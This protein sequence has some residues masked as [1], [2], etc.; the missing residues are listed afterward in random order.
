[1]QHARTTLLI[2]ALLGGTAVVLGA[3]GAHALKQV[4]AAPQ[5]ASFETAVRFQ[6]YHAFFLMGVGLLQ[7]GL[8]LGKALRW[9]A[10]LGWVGTLCFSGSIYVLVLTPLGGFPWVL[11]TPAGGVLLI[12]AWLLLG[13]ALWKLPRRS[14]T[15][16]P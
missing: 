8:G 2:A 5:L 9:A 15:P 1:M 3:L 14:P 13:A 12:L 16:N 4:L 7:Q 10:T 11:I 6:F